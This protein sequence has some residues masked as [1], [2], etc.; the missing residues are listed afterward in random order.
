[1][2]IVLRLVVLWAALSVLIAVVA[3]DAVRLR[4]ERSRPTRA[5][6][7]HEA[8]AAPGPYSATV[9]RVDSAAPITAPDVG[10]GTSAHWLDPDVRAHSAAGRT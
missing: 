1:M 9:R 3:G 2:D 6:I 5:G 7:V 4:E 10:S 8:A